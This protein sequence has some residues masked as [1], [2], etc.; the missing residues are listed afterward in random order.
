MQRVEVLSTTTK[1]KKIEVKGGFYS[2]E[3][4]KSELGYS[5]NIGSNEVIRACIKLCS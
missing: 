5:P 1:S 2:E 3:D 4:M